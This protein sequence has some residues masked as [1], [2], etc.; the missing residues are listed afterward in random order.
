ML[1]AFLIPVY[2]SRFPYFRADVSQT[3]RTFPMPI[4]KAK[5]PIKAH[6]IINNIIILISYRY[7]YFFIFFSFPF[8]VPRVPLRPY[9]H[10]LRSIRHLRLYLYNTAGKRETTNLIY[11]MPSPPLLEFAHFQRRDLCPAYR[12]PDQPF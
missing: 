7:T 10:H 1:A 11:G 9:S 2:V 6:H 3:S 8:P 4:G 12:P 5:P